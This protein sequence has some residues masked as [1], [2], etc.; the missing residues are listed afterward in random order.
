[1][2]ATLSAPHRRSDPVRT[3][4]LLG[5]LIDARSW[6]SLLE[7]FADVVVADTTAWGGTRLRLPSYALAAGL[8]ETLADLTTRHDP[9]AATVSGE[10]TVTASVTIG[11]R[12]RRPGWRMMTCYRCLV[13]PGPAG[14]LV[15]AVV[16]E[17]SA[18]VLSLGS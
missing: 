5:E 15:T 13:V 1:M 9:L 18:A 8:G 2:A 16:A 3:A 4:V 7:V 10:R 12:G 14:W 11:P 6:E 17:P